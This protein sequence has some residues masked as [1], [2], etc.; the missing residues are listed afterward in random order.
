MSLGPA[1]GPGQLKPPARVQGLLQDSWERARLGCVRGQVLVW[2]RGVW[3]GRISPK[4]KEKIEAAPA[5]TWSSV[6]THP[7]QWTGRPQ[8]KPQVGSHPDKQPDCL[9]AETQ[10]AWVGAHLD[11]WL[12]APHTGPKQGIGL[13]A[14]QSMVRLRATT[15]KST[16][17]EQLPLSP[18]AKSPAGPTGSL[19][20]RQNTQQRGAAGLGETAFPRKTWPSGGS[21][22]P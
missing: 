7:D 16:N 17:S 15:P 11:Q 21:T 19:G 18:C 20:Q 13:L 2:T 1:W 5:Y 22:T 3:I 9:G 12:A 4:E 10:S 6:G 8:L 14:T